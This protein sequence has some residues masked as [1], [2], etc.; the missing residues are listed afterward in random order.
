VP[1][2]PASHGCVRMMAR[3]APLMYAFATYG[4][5]VDVVREYA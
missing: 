5:P 2:Y 1:A 3:D 4:T